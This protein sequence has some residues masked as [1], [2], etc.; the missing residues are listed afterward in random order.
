MTG[1]KHGHGDVQNVLATHF[2]SCEVLEFFARVTLKIYMICEIVS[3]H[4]VLCFLDMTTGEDTDFKL[5]LAGLPDL[6]YSIT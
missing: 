3:L 6:K 2:T 4:Y 1:W 5:R